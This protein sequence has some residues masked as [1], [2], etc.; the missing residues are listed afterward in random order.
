MFAGFEALLEKLSLGNVPDVVTEAPEDDG[1]GHKRSISNIMASSR[2]K[3]GREEGLL[4]EQ[5]TML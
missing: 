3:R 1:H 4:T 2:T 5:V